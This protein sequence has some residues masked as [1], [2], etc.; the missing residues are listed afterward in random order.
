MESN[1]KKAY[2]KIILSGLIFGSNGIV[3]SYIDLSSYEI[4]LTRTVV[5]GLSLLAICLITGKRLPVREHPGQAL[6]VVL[7]GFAMGAGWMCLYEAYDEIGVGVGALLG[8][9]GPVIVMMLSPLFFGE[10]LTAPKL[11]GFFTVLAGVFLLNGALDGTLNPR[12]VFFGIMSSVFY[13]V[14]LISNKKATEIRGLEN[15]TLQIISAFVAVAAFV[16]YRQGFSFSVQPSD[17]L[18]IL[19][20]GIVNTGFACYCYFS[21]V[22]WLPVQTV[23]VVGYLEPL[24][25]VILGAVILREPMGVL[26]IIGAV[27]VLG[28]AF[29]AETCKPKKHEKA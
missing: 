24:S 3:A 25:A 20:L 6:Y 28:G 29:F 9:C 26:K 17:V 8:N 12:G 16:V 19:V 2:I 11:T 1:A 5:G 22:A 13:A 14:M 4:V 10:K 18:P 7:S 27:L 21:S 23:A 15:T